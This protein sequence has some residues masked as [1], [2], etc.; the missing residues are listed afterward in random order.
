MDDTGRHDTEELTLEPAPIVRSRR[1]R[2]LWAVLAAV[3]L[4]AGALVVTSAGDDATQRP[5][6]PVALG[7]SGGRAE[8]AMAADSMLAWVTYVAGD[9]L[10]ALAGEA[11]AYR[12]R[13][14]VDEA[15]VRALAGALGVDGDIVHEGPAWKVGDGDSTLE[16]Y[17]GGGAQWWYSAGG[18]DVAIAGSGSSSGS[19]GSTGGAESCTESSDD[20]VIDCEARPPIS[21][22]D[23]ECTQKDGCA[24][25]VPLPVEPVP[26]ADLPTAD[27]ARA[28]ALDLLT[29]TGMDTDDAIVTVDGPYD[30]WYVTVEPRVDGIPSGL[31][32]NVAVGSEGTINNAAGFV[33][34]P[35]RLGD[36][37]VLDTRAAIDR[38][39]A[40]MGD[41]APF[42]RGDGV[43][44]AKD[45]DAA[46]TTGGAP[47]VGTATAG[48]GGDPCAPP[49][50]ASDGCG[51]TTGGD[52][53]EACDPID[54]N[55]VSTVIDCAPD[56][57][58][59]GTTGGTT[60]SVDPPDTTIVP[61]CK[62][63]PD[64]SEICET[65]CAEPAPRDGTVPG[66]CLPPCPQAVPGQDIAV[67][68]PESLDCPGP[69]PEPTDPP[70]P[71]PEPEPVEI[72]LVD[73]EPTLVLLAANDGS[74]DAYLVPGYRFTDADGGRVDLPAVA[75]ESLTTPSTETTVP[76]TIEPKPDPVPAPEP[77]PCEVLEEQDASGTTHTVQPNASCPEPDLVIGESYYVDIDT[78]CSGGSFVL[79]D[80]VWITDN[81]EVAGWADPAERHEGGLF[82]LDA[83]D[84]GTFVGD[85]AGTLVADFS[86]LGPAEDIFC[87][88]QPRG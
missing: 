11:P 44:I 22:D 10:P 78:E 64:G 54:D 68:A 7:S 41:W 79:G 66:I 3:G 20:V 67:G 73:A 43:A 80:Q 81:P 4:A 25:P 37:P 83:H 15:Q 42:G 39:N 28:I 47:D 21:P 32:A 65:E 85:E 62:V 72:V 13:G 50:G 5:G 56:G 2:A 88:P 31:P 14:N 29:A 30:A 58:D 69:P 70:V 45:I 35:E 75:D 24:E 51:G 84:H 6:L 9:D 86:A 16:V 40:H 63:Q 52:E 71:M 46:G 34:T 8:G 53:C 74:T 87:T 12:L 36:Y 1:P 59:C 60:G 26:A 17:E 38:A 77:Q 49:D 27:E 19:A 23:V 55:P 61:G 48:A 76:G 18:R 57:S 82:T 33:G